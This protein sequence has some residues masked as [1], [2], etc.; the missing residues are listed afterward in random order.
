MTLLPPYF[1][2]TLV[3]L[4]AWSDQISGYRVVATGF[5]VGFRTGAQND[6]GRDLFATFLVTN[7]HVVADGDHLVARV[8]R[9]TESVRVN[10]VIP[11]ESSGWILHARYDVAVLQADLGQLRQEGAS[12]AF[13]SD[14]NLATTDKMR[15]LGV[16][17]GD[18]IFVLGFPMGLAGSQKSYGIARGGIVARFDEEIV[19]LESSF[20]ID[21]SVFPGNSGGPVAVRPSITSIEGTP[22]I[23]RAYVIGIVTSYLPFTDVAI[24]QQT[25]EPRI[26]FQENSGLAA[27]AP[28]DAVRE[29]VDPLLAPAAPVELE[30]ATKAETGQPEEPYE[31]GWP[32]APEPPA[33]PRAD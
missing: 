3:A 17:A 33:A 26:T 4:E 10:I 22:A 18:D 19:N 31:A 23:T 5:T 6:E 9:G 29:L 2:D 20:L 11:P 24:S 13:I 7:R 21:S 1:L 14:D 25:G 12:V 30:T 15:E 16:A 8:N 27:V 32:P 28:I